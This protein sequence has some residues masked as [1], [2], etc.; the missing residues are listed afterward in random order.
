MKVSVMHYSNALIPRGSSF[1]ADVATHKGGSQ[2]SH[3]TD[4]DKAPFGT[5]R[6]KEGYSL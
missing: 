2:Y 5:S 1:L 4:K 6:A 3:C